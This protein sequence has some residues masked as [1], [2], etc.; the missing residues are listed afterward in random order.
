MKRNANIYEVAELAQVSPMTVTRA[1]NGNAPVAEKTRKKIMEAA[2]KLD[3]RPSLFARKLSGGSTNSIGILWS[4]APPH[5]SIRQVR[6]ISLR[7]YE[8]GY[9]CHVADSLSEE[10]IVKQ[11]LA[12]FIDHRV[13]AV[14]FQNMH[15]A[16]HDGTIR[17]LL[18]KLPAC[19]MVSN[20]A[21][22]DL[23]FD[24]LVIDE[25]KPIHDMMKQFAAAGKKRPAYFFNSYSRKVNLFLKELKEQGFQGGSGSLLQV[26]LTRNM[27]NTYHWLAYAEYLEDRYPDR[28]PFDAFFVSP[29]EGAAALIHYLK[30]RGIRVPEDIAV[31][32]INN[33]DMAEFFDPPIAS[34]NREEGKVADAIEQMLMVRLADLQAPRQIRSLS[35]KYI[36]RLSAGYNP[37]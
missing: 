18:K 24:Q 8:R 34:I 1:F 19:I 12:E 6:D 36:P 33:S 29:D 20:E 4:L 30:K 15:L 14:V 11:C 25:S 23:P 17:N 13:D 26:S 9:A 5:S 31:C 32:G 7:M 21:C 10:K 35:M 27:S 16:D 28:I 3:Y 37:T 22:P 2:E